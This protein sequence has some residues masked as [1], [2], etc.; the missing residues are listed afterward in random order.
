MSYFI[1]LNE[2]LRAMETDP[3]TASD[4]IKR[5]FLYDGQYVTANLGII[6]EIS[7]QITKG[8]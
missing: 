8:G 3:S 4:P 1:H 2:K 5:M 7:P 6:K